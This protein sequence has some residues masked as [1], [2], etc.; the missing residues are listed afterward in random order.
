MAFS[1]FMCKGI[2]ANILISEDKKRSYRANFISIQKYGGSFTFEV[3]AVF[4]YKH[5]KN[6][7]LWEGLCIRELTVLNT[8]ELYC[9]K[10]MYNGCSIT[11]TYM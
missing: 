4:P 7:A 10:E 9:L 2:L 3:F 6:R 11:K 8:H 5:K 1:R